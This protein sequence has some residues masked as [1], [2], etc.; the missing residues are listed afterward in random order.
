M[1]HQPWWI[2][3]IIYISGNIDNLIQVHLPQ[4]VSSQSFVTKMKC[5]VTSNTTHDVL[6]SKEIGYKS[7]KEICSRESKKVNIG[8]K[9]DLER[10]TVENSTLMQI[11]KQTFIFGQGSSMSAHWEV[12]SKFFS[13]HNIEPNWLD[14][15]GIPGHYDEELGGWT[16]CVGKVWGTEYWMWWLSQIII[17]LRG[18]RQ[19]LLLQEAMLVSTDDQK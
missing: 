3:N 10:M 1:W 2:K 14:C 18:M 19:I 12:L 13:I 8:F 5:Q 11:P 17:R 16:G 15:N 7:Y 6:I 9:N 4:R